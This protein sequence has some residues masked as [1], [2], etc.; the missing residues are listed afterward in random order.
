ML[1]A[2]VY[3]LFSIVVL[4]GAFGVIMDIRYGGG[5]AFPDRTSTPLLPDSALE[6]VADLPYPPGNIAVAPDGRLFF[7]F[8]P[9]G[10]PEYNL[11]QLVDGQA[12]PLLL[13]DGNPPPVNSVLSLRIDQQNRL[14][15]LDY[16]EHGSE[17]PQLLAIDLNTMALVH[18]HRF[19]SD[20][21]GL[22]SHL[23]DFQVDNS[24]R[25]IFIADASILGLTPALIVYDIEQQQAR[26][27]LED[28]E[29]VVADDYVP[30]VEGMKMLMFGVFAIRP[31]V[32][33]IAL[34]RQNE[35]LYFAPVT[36]EH[37]HRVKVS[38]LL[39]THLSP[40]QLAARVERF[41]EKTMSDGITTDN[42]GNIYI[43][44]LE[45]SAITRLSPK[46]ELSTLLRHED[47]RWPDG[48]SF[49]PDGYLY[50]T[51]SALQY[52]IAK[53]ASYIQQHGPYQIFRVQTGER[54]AAGH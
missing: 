40:D 52:V 39:D 30:V 5:D 48:F 22:G 36:D 15:L 45:H 12:Q 35:W 38:D 1:R 43:S 50:V 14:W 54:A 53:P 13:A 7:S 51:A 47:L 2:L 31:G 24:G 25:F 33:S 3:I 28:H 6:K 32:D 23:N 27:L 42:A 26:R 11:A 37:M 21:A 10:K 46:G 44:D 17:T 49:G 9:E 34:D 8:H 29:S 41:A 18:E 20:I 19:S 16:A 4:I